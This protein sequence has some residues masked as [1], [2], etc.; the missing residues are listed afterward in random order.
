MD[1]DG[2][3]SLM[4]LCCFTCP[5]FI[6]VQC[7]ASAVYAVIVY[8]SGHLSVRPSVCPSIHMS[9]GCIVP[10]R[11]N[12]NTAYLSASTRPKVIASDSTVCRILIHNEQLEQVDMFPYLGTENGECT[13]EFRTRLN[14]G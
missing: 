6:T 11:L 14:T 8:L 5:P 1:I 4:Q 7:Y 10:K 12:V 9:H 13:T 2:S 3:I